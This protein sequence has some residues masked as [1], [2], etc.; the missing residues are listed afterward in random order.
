M[1]RLPKNNLLR[2]ILSTNYKKIRRTKSCWNE[3]KCQPYLFFV[4]SNQYAISKEREW[5]R[6]K[7]GAG[8]LETHSEF[9]FR[10]Y[11]V[12]KAS[13]IKKNRLRSL[14]IQLVQFIEGAGK[15]TL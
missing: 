15:K 11:Q 13:K 8:K 1:F 5:D 4:I 2:K 7:L 14:Y 3:L 10:I 6:N 9:E 12:Q